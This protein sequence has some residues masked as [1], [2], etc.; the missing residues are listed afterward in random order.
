M[1]TQTHKYKFLYLSGK[2]CGQKYGLQQEVSRTP[3]VKKEI[4]IL[5][6]S[7]TYPN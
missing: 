6:S 2:N 3:E 1:N 7:V 5:I 4:A